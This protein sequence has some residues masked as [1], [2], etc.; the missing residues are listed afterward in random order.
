MAY[1]RDIRAEAW[2]RTKAGLASSQRR[3][4]SVGVPIISAIIGIVI[5]TVLHQPIPLTLLVGVISALLGYGLVV[6]SDWFGNV[7][8]LPAEIDAQRLSKITDLDAEIRRLK[9]PE[10]PVTFQFTQVVFT[11]QQNAHVIIVH[12]KVLNHGSALTLHDIR[13]TTESDKTISLRPTFN[14]FP[15]HAIDDI[16]FDPGMVEIGYLQFD[17]S[18]IERDWVLE[19]LDNRGRSYRE[20]IP[21]ELY[22]RS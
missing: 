15:K 17:G 8:R 9:N 2:K 18:G 14:A 10:K 6:L 20:P 22:K 4:T 3:K 7:R 19:Y 13:L 1:W 11:Q 12:A 16:R 5:L 21:R